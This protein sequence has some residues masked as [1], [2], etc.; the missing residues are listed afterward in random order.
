MRERQGYRLL[1]LTFTTVVA[2]E[3]VRSVLILDISKWIQKKSKWIEC[4]M[5]EKDKHQKVTNVL[6]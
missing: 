5:Y 2:V 1:V 3:V 6:F 4:R